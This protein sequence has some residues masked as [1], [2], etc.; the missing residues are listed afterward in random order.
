MRCNNCYELL[1]KPDVI[2]FVRDDPG[3]V[4]VVGACINCGPEAMTEAFIPAFVDEQGLLFTTPGDQRHASYL[5]TFALEFLEL[6]QE[7]YRPTPLPHY[8]LSPDQ[9]REALCAGAVLLSQNLFLKVVND[10]RHFT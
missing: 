3:L 8:K 10:W 1:I 4:I 6:A 9:R 5:H 7:A 2:Q